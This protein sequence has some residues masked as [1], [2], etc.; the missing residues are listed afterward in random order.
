M[1]L[2]I[3]G[4]LLQVRLLIS[5]WSW[6]Y[7]LSFFFF[8]LDPQSC[9]WGRLT[10]PLRSGQSAPVEAA[11]AAVIGSGEAFNSELINLSPGL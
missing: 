4:E 1:V 2:Y 3:A 6:S 8:L 11:L 5:R 9:P 10:P 7:F